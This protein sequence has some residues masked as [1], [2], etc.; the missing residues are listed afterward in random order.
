M[1][2]FIMEQLDLEITN[3]Y[4]ELYNFNSRKVECSGIIKDLMVKLGQLPTKNGMMGVVVVDVPNM[5]GI[6]LS[7][8]WPKKVGGTMQ[9]DLK[10]AIVLFFA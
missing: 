5:Y 8:T 3:P 9:M 6:L 4:H 10:Y 7:N 2:N 1:P